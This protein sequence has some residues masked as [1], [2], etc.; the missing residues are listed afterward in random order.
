MAVFH[1]QF[2]GAS[3]GIVFGAV[4]IGALKVFLKQ[5]VRSSE[6]EAVS[7]GFGRCSMNRFRQF[8]MEHVGRKA[9][10]F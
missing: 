7:L 4:L 8:L 6:S 5:L 10:V 2:E 9:K 1:V 3:A